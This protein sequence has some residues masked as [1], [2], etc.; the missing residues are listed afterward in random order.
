M[1]QSERH[2][3]AREQSIGFM[4]EAARHG[5]YLDALQWLNTL[6]SVDIRFSATAETI[7][8]A[9]RDRAR[10][11]RTGGEQ[12]AD[13]GRRAEVTDYGGL[14]GALLEQ[15]YDGIVISD[16]ADGWML[17]CSRSFGRMTGYGRSE[18]LGRTSVELGLIEP[19]VRESAVDSIEEERTSG[20]HRTALRRK[21]GTARTVEF[22]AQLLAGDQLLLTI[23]R[24][25]S[26]RA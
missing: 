5:D 22:S 12:R 9:W 11:F 15:S 24:D 7:L 20:L 3:R 16:V 18:L 17:E 4:A 10:R 6:A 14:F 2:E 13:D 19:T 25:I 1:S 26:D 23:V 21:D 8:A